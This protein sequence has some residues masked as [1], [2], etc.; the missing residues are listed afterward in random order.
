MS[1]YDVELVKEILR[2]ILWSTRTIMRRFAPITSYEDFLISDAG[3]D[4]LDSICMQLIAIGESVKHLD[5]I[6]AGKLL[7]HYPHIEWKR[8]M[9]MRDIL[10]HHYFD[11]DAEIVYA[12]CD[13]QVEELS[14]TVQQMIIDLE[15]SDHRRR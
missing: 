8:V 3:L 15:E 2:Q 10:S 1:D 9:G 13:K 5:D 6:T 12:T 4:K 7:P 14:Q 11:I